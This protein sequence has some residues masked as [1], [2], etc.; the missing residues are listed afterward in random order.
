MV[1][2]RSA[3][4]GGAR[5]ALLLRAGARQRLD[6]AHRQTVGDRPLGERAPR[7]V[8]VELENRAAVAFRQLA[9]DDRVKHLV[10]QVEQTQRVGDR[11]AALPH[12]LGDLSRRQVELVDQRRVATR[13]LDRVEVLAHH[14][15]DEGE[16]ERLALIGAAHDCGHGLEA[17]LIGRTPAALAGDDLVA[18]VGRRAH[19]D[20]LHDAV[21]LDR[22][23]EVV[24]RVLVEGP[25]RLAR[26]RLHLINRQR[27]EGRLAACGIQQG[28]ESASES[29][30]SSHAQPPPGR[31][32]N[33]RPLRASAGRTGKW[34]GHATAPRRDARSAG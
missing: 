25:A 27:Y 29:S 1:E 23:C 10:R 20:R 15:L 11:R 19:D 2:P 31:V 30:G 4:L 12:L 13:S 34:G 32:G 24:E 26:V 7:V 16:R 28:V 5:R 6:L 21:L 3:I 14:V 9:G 22:P 18:A 33:T 17:S 8:V